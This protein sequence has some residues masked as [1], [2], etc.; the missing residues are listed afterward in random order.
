MYNANQSNDYLPGTWKGLKLSGNGGRSVSITCPECSQL[1]VL[2][3]HTI[4]PDGKVT[5]SVVCPKEG[6]DFHEFVQ[7]DGWK[8]Q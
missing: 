6:C 8:S 5:P 1:A 2:T 7:L 3:D 4:S